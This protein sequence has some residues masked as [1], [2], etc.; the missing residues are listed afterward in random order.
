MRSSDYTGCIGWPDAEQV[1]TGVLLHIQ[2][3]ESDR[4]FHIASLNLQAIPVLSPD[5]T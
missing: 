1:A 2:M 3:V 4:T 5:V